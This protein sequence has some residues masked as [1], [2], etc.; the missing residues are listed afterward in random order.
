ALRAERLHATD[1]TSSSFRLVWPRLLRQEGGYYSL[2]Y[3]PGARA[4]GRSAQ[5]LPAALGSLVLGG[6]APETTYEV[7]LTPESNVRY[8]P[9]LT[10]SVTTLP[11]KNRPWGQG[12]GSWLLPGDAGGEN[13]MLE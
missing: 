6:L 7:A 5:Q 3:G 11:G 2:E 10:T 1:I 4:A 8:F 12:D 13:R 9:T